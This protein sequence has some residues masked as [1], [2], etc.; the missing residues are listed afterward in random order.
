MRSSFEVS[1]ATRRAVFVADGSAPAQGA[2]AAGAGLPGDEQS[3][4]EREYARGRED[5]RA[6]LASEAGERVSSAVAALEQAL[7]ELARV[8]AEEQ[9]GL[10]T[11]VVELAL[12]LSGRLVARELRE[13]CEA[14]APLVEEALALLPASD[15][16]ALVLANSD[17]ERVR[18]GHAPEL[19]RLRSEWRAE[20]VADPTLSPGEAVV[21]SGAAT[22]ELRLAA[23]LERFREGLLER[24]PLP[25]D[26]T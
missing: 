19:E 23:V 22:V 25:E 9:E 3:A 13:D 21:R 4:L 7:G 26:A 1:P 20:L 14:L 5:A 10:R 18:A 16:M 8:A 12:A 15:P 6:E 17:A 24:M 11:A 2:V